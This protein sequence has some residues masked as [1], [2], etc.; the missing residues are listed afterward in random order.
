MPSRLPARALVAGG[1]RSAPTEPG[2]ET[3]RWTRA[4]GTQR[5]LCEPPLLRQVSYIKESFIKW[6]VIK[7]G[8]D[9]SP[10]WN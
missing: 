6:G 1:D 2:G 3:G 5:P 8:S 9:S 4:T 10:L 7:G